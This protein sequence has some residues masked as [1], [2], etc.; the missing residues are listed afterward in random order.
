MC[1]SERPPVFAIR[2]LSLA[3]QS[4]YVRYQLPLV[5]TSIV[6]YGRVI[7]V[8]RMLLSIGV[9]IRYPRVS[10]NHSYQLESVPQY[11]CTPVYAVLEY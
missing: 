5:L 8:E 6:S 4:A 9:E 11:P 7:A 1:E 10:E 2:P 3:A